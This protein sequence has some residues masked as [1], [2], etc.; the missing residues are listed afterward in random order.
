MSSTFHAH[1]IAAPGPV[2]YPLLAAGD[3][4]IKV[5]F[6]KEGEA[7]AV[8]DSTVSLVRRGLRI[9]RV[10]VKGLMQVFPSL[11][12][13]MVVWRKGSAADVLLRSY[14]TKAGKNIEIVYV[15]D[16]S[17]IMKLLKSNQVDSAVVSSA[18]G[19]GIPFEELLPE[20]PGSCGVHLNRNEEMILSAYMKGIEEFKRNP[21]E[22]ANRVASKLPMKVDPSFIKGTMTNSILTVE[23]PKDFMAFKQL[24]SSVI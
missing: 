16:Q 18:V 17:E 8:F 12:N 9:D 2:V 23:K 7:D 22:A 5:D 20:V 15:D 24:I 19:K 14:I 1:V 10:L 3:G 21:E 6:G 4:R 11:G 13:K